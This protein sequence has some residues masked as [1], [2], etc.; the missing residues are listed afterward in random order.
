LVP[1]HPVELAGKLARVEVDDLVALLELV[2]LLQHGDGDHD[3]VLL[4]GVDAVVVVEDDV[5][6]QDEDLVRTGKTGHARSVGRRPAALQ[7][8][9]RTAITWNL[10]SPGV[11]LRRRWPRGR[12]RSRCAPSTRAAPRSLPPRDRSRDDRSP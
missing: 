2:D 6:V 5:R 12:E 4:E 8:T 1:A 9:T 10:P 3:R 11:P 7:V